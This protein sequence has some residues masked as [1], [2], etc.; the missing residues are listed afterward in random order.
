MKNQTFDNMSFR[1]GYIFSIREAPKSHQACIDLKNCYFETFADEA[2]KR[3]MDI[4]KNGGIDA[5][6]ETRIFCNMSVVPDKLW[7]DRIPRWRLRHI[8][9]NESL[10]NLYGTFMLPCGEPSLDESWA[11]LASVFDENMEAY[12]T[13][14]CNGFR[15]IKS[16]R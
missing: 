7:D 10:A 1:D 13:L 12:S 4:F 6:R 11:F 15:T 16:E 9:T 14:S 5:P 3:L 8:F 2:H